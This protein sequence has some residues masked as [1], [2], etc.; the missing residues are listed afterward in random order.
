[1]GRAEPA[2]VVMTVDGVLPEVR[3]P[4]CHALLFKGVMVGQIRCRTCKVFVNFGKI[5]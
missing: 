3:W 2:A 4:R 5:G 1:M